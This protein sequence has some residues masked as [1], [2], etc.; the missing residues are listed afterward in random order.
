MRDPLL[1]NWIVLL[2]AAGAVGGAI[3]SFLNVVAWRLP[4]G[5][6][7][8]HPPSACPHCRSA[9]RPWHNVPVFGWLL[10]RGR[11]YDCGEPISPRY[12][13]VEA[14]GAAMWALLFVTVM[15]TPDSLAQPRELIGL[16]L[17]GAYFSALLAAALIDADHFI[18]PD[19]ITLPLIPLGIAVNA[20]LEAQGI[21]DASFVASVFGAVAG[22]GVLLAI[23]LLGRAMYGREAMGVG[24]IKLVA[25]IGAWQG[26]HPTLLVTVL[27]GSMAG[28][29]VGGFRIWRMGRQK[30]GKIPFGPFLIFGAY[31]AFV[32]GDRVMAL[33]IPTL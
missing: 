29:L 3:A 10:L 27:V 18:L 8:V 2:C 19:R 7:V 13:I 16:G 12:P 23:A 30:G 31:V 5:R 11:C 32:A 22:G 21:G 14:V 26:L 4:A 33:L 6:S 24:D 20:V 28:S 17:F 9:I 25:A 15:G 1:T